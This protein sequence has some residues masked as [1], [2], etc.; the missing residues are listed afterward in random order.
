MKCY[1]TKDENVFG[2]VKTFVEG[3]PGE[4]VVILG[5]NVYWNVDEIRAKFPNEKII[6]YQLEQIS[7]WYD[8]SKRGAIKIRSNQYLRALNECDE[9]WD[10]DAENVLFLRDK[11]HVPLYL[12]PLQVCEALNYKIPRD[13]IV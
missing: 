13:F 3:L 1:I 12:K 10:Y 7:V 8:V 2:A 4:G 6:I 11:V 9:I 5:Y